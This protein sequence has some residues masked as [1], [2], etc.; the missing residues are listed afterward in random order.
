MIRRTRSRLLELFCLVFSIRLKPE[1]RYE[2]QAA[3][4]RA[5]GIGIGVVEEI[6]ACGPVRSEPSR[7]GRLYDADD[8]RVV[9]IAAEMLDLGATTDD[10][11]TYGAYTTQRCGRCGPELCPSRCDAI[12]ELRRLLVR[13][14]ARAADD[15]Q[16]G[17]SRRIARSISSIDTLS[18][19]M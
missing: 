4:A 1:E 3:V 10:I 19:L 11:I 16:P 17:R 15:L 12:D 2:S 14:A 7:P 8:V 13:M 9:A 18:E 5:C 6:E